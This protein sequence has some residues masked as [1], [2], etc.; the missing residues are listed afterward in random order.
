MGPRDALRRPLIA[1]VNRWL[2]YKASRERSV[3]VIGLR[4]DRAAFEEIYRSSELL[5]EYLTP[6]RHAFYRE[7][8]EICA[9]LDPTTVIDVGCG[10]GHLLAAIQKAS[11]GV[12]QLV[13]VDHTS[14][15]IER[16]N[17]VVP[18]A[19]GI[20]QSLYDL[21]PPEGQFD[22]VLCTEVLE[23]LP[24]PAAALSVLRDL[25]RP[26]G[27][28]VVTVPDGERDDYAGHVNFWNEVELREFVRSVGTPEVTR[29]RE[30][31]LIAVVDV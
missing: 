1:A 22:L 8:A 31:D 26:G 13:G 2:D 24:N 25:C 15:A 9:R 20:Q 10:P 18:S 12:R 14:A 7:V 17:D 5:Q 21:R 16:L 29:S 6:E 30:G 27:H 23:H 3:K 4:N 11:P 28:V 19:T